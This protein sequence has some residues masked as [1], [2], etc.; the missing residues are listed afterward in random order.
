ME[1]CASALN[2]ASLFVT[3]VPVIGF[4]VTPSGFGIRITLGLDKWNLEVLTF[5]C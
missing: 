1:N 5:V 2:C 3:D 4:L